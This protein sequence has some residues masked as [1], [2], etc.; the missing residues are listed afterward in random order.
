MRA[1]ESERNR[2]L[3]ARQRRAIV[4]L[5][6]CAT[7][8]EAA[9]T[10]RVGKTTLYSWLKEEPFALAVHEARWEQSQEALACLRSSLLR[11]AQKL[12]ELLNSG[13]EMVAFRAA[14]ALV[15]HGLKGIELEEQE[16]RIGE[17]EALV[18]ALQQKG[19]QR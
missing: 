15:E 13:N 19:L 11:A 9:K 8:E 4:A 18:T 10:A 14:T 12:S 5:L 7:T 6:T 1:N 16:E 2:T 3:T 17:L